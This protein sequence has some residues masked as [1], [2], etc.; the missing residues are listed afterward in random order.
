MIPSFFPCKIAFW[1]QYF[2][3]YIPLTL[4]LW[5]KFVIK[6]EEQNKLDGMVNDLNDNEKK[7]IKIEDE[8]KGGDSL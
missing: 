2:I 1:K 5:N 6:G 4:S 7:N 3:A 8:S